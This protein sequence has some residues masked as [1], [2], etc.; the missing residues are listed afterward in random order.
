MK[1]LVFVGGGHA[2][3][4]CLGQIKKDPL[5][6]CRVVLISPSLHQYYSGM[7]SG[8]AEGL[9][10]IDDIRIDLRCLSESAGA[11]FIMDRIVAIDPAAG[12][13]TGANGAIYDYDLVSFDIGSDDSIPEEMKELLSPNKPNFLFPDRLLQLRKSAQ[14]IIVGGGAAGVELAFSINA[15]RQEQGLPLNTI[16]LSS[17]P[18]LSGL[19]ER[20]I[21]SAEAIA[22]RKS[23]NFFT[24]Y[25]VEVI[26]RGSVVTSERQAFP[27]SDLLWA[28]GPASF[29]LFEDAG[30]PTDEKGFLLVT[31]TLNV[32][33]HPEI[34]GAG[35]CVT[36]EHY[37]GL[38]KNGVYAVRQGPVLWSNV[39]SRL[40]SEELASFTPQKRFTSI[41]S[42]GNGEALL[43]NGG[44]TLHGRLPMKVKQYI[45]LKFMKRYKKIY[46]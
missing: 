36:L 9:Y 25:Q 45:D 35:D 7:F 2:H 31:N 46:E 18:L 44:I 13:L 1:T 3:L 6:D 42:T 17:S 32:V 4:H 39:K 26:D 19:G 27:F 15:W 8:F 10:S 28:A 5:P 40:A 30:L 21:K 41:L 11:R 16:L 22:Y 23:L 37:P 43:L 38:P 33:G 20:A 29:R 24:G 14:P 12:Q 34:F